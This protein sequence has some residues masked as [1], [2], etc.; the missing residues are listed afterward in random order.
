MAVW[1][2][3]RNINEDRGTEG[4]RDGRLQNRVPAKCCQAMAGFASCFH[5]PNLI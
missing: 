1:L 5:A 3:G 4:E 2:E